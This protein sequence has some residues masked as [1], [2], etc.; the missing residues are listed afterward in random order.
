MSTRKKRLTP[1]MKR[2]LKVYDKYNCNISKTCQHPNVDITRATY[3]NWR[4]GNER[5]DEECSHI[6]EGLLDIA[7]TMLQKNVIAGKE[8]SVFFFLKTK[9]KKRGYIERQE[10][11]FDEHP[12]IEAMKYL[13]NTKS[14]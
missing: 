13:G 11:Q 5:F 6:E 10:I 9:G 2:F 12:F 7:E 8:A 3:Y 1:K 4:N 14:G